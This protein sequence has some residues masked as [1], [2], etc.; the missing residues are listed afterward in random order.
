MFYKYLIDLTHILDKD[1]LQVDKNQ[2]YSEFKTLLGT[3]VLFRD[4]WSKVKLD[5][6]E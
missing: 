2:S 1:P 6:D 4:I 5:L 3:K